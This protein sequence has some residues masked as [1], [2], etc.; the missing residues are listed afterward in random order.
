MAEDSW[1]SKY[2]VKY[3]SRRQAERHY[4]RDGTAYAA[5]ALPAHFSAVASVLDH[6][7]HR[8]ESSWLIE[9]VIEWGAG[10]GGSL[11]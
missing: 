6:L 4:E 8:L 7:K 11:W 10:M 9:N 5:V 1:D 3:R 2:D